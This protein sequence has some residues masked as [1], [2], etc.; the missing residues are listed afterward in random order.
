MSS[1]SFR[2]FST[3]A[4]MMSL[5]TLNTFVVVAFA[6]VAR[7]QQI[8]SRMRKPRAWAATT[9]AIPLLGRRDSAAVSV[10]FPKLSPAGKIIPGCEPAP[11]RC[12]DHV[13]V[14]H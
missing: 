12:G 5:R 7:V 6:G 2:Q 1:S 11:A 14:L 3:F 10:F 4:Y 8:C 9:E 13:S